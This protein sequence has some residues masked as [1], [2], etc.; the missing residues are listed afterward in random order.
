[1]K[2]P[3]FVAHIAS[4]PGNTELVRLHC[5]QEDCAWFDKEFEQCAIL[6]LAGTSDFIR[7]ILNDMKRKMPHEEQF[8]R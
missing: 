5:L 8:R 4:E 1:M 7:H 2:C 3:L 6:T